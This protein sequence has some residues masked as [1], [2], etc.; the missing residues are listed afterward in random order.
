M[1]YGFCFFFDLFFMA[2]NV[3]HFQFLFYLFR[4]MAGLSVLPLI[5]FPRFF[6]R[7]A[8]P[9]SCFLLPLLLCIGVFSVTFLSIFNSGGISGEIYVFLQ[10]K[11]SRFGG[12]LLE[13]H[14]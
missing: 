6:R 9:S 1:K 10:E 14:K 8:L 13:S 4:F 12:L 11:V 3:P 5:C 2:W 7:N